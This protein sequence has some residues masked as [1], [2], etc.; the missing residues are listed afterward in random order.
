MTKP[1]LG[2]LEQVDVREYWVH[3]ASEFTPWLAHAE[4]IVLL[5]KA[6]GLDLQVE[7]VEKSVGPFRADILCRDTT[8]GRYVLIENQLERTDHGH[9]GQLMTYAAGLDAAT[10]IWVAPR[11]TEEHRA[12]LDWLNRITVPGFD[13]FGLEIELWKIGDS[14]LAPK[15]NLVSQPNDW[16]KTVKAKADSGST[17]AVSETEQLH[18]DFWAQFRQYMEDRGSPVR[19][20]KPSTSSWTTLGLGRSNVNLYIA[21]NRK[22]K[23]SGMYLSAWGT[24]HREYLQLMRE[25]F[26]AQIDETLVGAKWQETA[27]PNESR[28]T[29]ERPS[30]LADKQSWSELND[31]LAERIE[32]AVALFRPIIKALGAPADAAIDG[33]IAVTAETVSPGEGGVHADQPSQ[34]GGSH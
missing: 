6:I 28:V 14:P 22:D 8:T 4:N 24:G 13:F 30:D 16:A 2:H 25:Q 10:V 17:G 31:W 3:E 1:A 18:L 5:G 29:L 34:G 15:L 11:F 27:T 32:K 23:R 26:G 20:G 7:T 12:A 19:M 33:P 21:N 9:L